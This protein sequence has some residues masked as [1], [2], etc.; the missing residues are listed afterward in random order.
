IFNRVQVKSVGV[1]Q[2]S[3]INQVVQRPDLSTG[4]WTGARA[5]VRPSLGLATPGPAY[6]EYKF[7]VP[8]EERHRVKQLLDSLYSGTD[9]YGS[10]W[11]HSLYFDTPDNR[12]F[13]ECLDGAACKEKFRLRGY[14]STGYLRPQIKRKTLAG[15]SKFSAPLLPPLDDNCEKWPEL[16]TETEAALEI[17]HIA[18]QRLNLEPVVKVSYERHRYRCFDYRLTFDDSIHVSKGVG[19]RGFV[20]G[21]YRFPFSVIEVKTRTDCPYLPGFG[22]LQLQPISFSKFFLGIC[23]LKGHSDVLNKY[24]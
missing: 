12:F 23:L 11:V 13:N 21:E 6:Y 22:M 14:N 10:G 8:G 2:R 16:Q 9:P 1:I 24:L 7:F 20:R 18:N 3:G 4:T 17:D 5:Q 15:V 19:M